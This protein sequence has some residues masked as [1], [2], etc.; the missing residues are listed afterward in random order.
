KTL[1]IVDFLK[2]M[3]SAM[4]GD[5]PAYNRIPESR[6]LVSQYLF[7]YSISGEPG[8][9]DSYVDYDYKSAKMVVLLKTGSNAYIHTLIEKLSA[10]M[11]HELGPDVQVSF[12]GD[13]AQTIAVTDAMVKGKL[14]NIVQICAAIFIISALVFRSVTAG[15]IVLTPLLVA[16]LAIFGAMGWIGIPLNI[17]NSLVSAMAVGIG[18][19]YAIYLLYRL[20]E[21]VG[22]R[23]DV[24]TAV[25]TRLAT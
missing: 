18:A 10:F 19:D 6:D 7:L 14:Q 25:R 11:A 8:D 23:R 2:R 13:V 3:N 22:E 9:F 5:D 21:Q 17:P 1:S 4:H 24:T 16:V 20:R 15:A 12:G